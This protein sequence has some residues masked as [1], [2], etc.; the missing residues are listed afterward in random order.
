VGETEG[1]ASSRHLGSGEEDQS[2]EKCPDHEADGDRKRPVGRFQ[3]EPGED[4]DVD[5]LGELPEQAGDDGGG[6]NRGD[7]ELA[8]GEDPVDE[9]EDS[10]AEDGRRYLQNGVGEG[11]KDEV[12]SV[13]EEEPGK[14]AV[15]RGGEGDGE[16]REQANGKREAEGDDG[17]HEVGTVFRDF[18][19]AIEGDF[20]GQ[21]DSTGGDEQRD[22]GDDLH[23]AAGVGKEAHVLDD[24]VLVRGQEVAEHVAEDAFHRR[25]VEDGALDGPGHHDEW[26]E[27]Q[28]GVC[29]DAEGVGVH[30][31][32]RK[33]AR[34]G[35]ELRP[36]SG[37]SRQ[38]RR[39]LGD[40]VRGRGWL[41]GQH[42]PDSMLGHMKGEMFGSNRSCCKGK[43]VRLSSF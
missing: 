5:T 21:E 41:D 28:D 6:K 17:V 16:E 4:E 42:G 34:E 7:G 12:L 19:D 2:G 40:G 8:V 1:V 33:V 15:L 43:P 30:L 25:R 9:K 27:R 39:G 32:L 31:A 3:V 22:D 38:A 11:T 13:A 24:E 20:E 26:K 36:P 29:G 23:F 14:Q 10:D 18:P 37:V 35:D